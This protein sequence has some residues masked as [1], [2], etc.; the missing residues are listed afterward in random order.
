MRE[1]LEDLDLIRILEKRLDEAGGV[2]QFA[3]QVQIPLIQCPV[4][5]PPIYWTSRFL[6]AL[7]VRRV[8]A[9]ERIQK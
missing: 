1:F 2:E 9:Y 7:N 3:A 4:T 8:Q 5:L 6:E